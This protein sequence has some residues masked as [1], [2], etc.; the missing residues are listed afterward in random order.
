MVIKPPPRRCTTQP[1]NTNHMTRV[2]DLSA[3][4]APPAPTD[5]KKRHEPAEVKRWEDMLK[6]LYNEL[7]EG[8]V[9]EM[10]SKPN[11]PDV[12]RR[13]PHAVKEHY[14]QRWREQARTLNSSGF[15]H[16]VDEEL[17]RKEIESLIAQQENLRR[18]ALPLYKVDPAD[19]DLLPVGRIPRGV[20]YINSACAVSVH[21]G[22][23]THVW[24]RHADET[25]E[26]WASDWLPEPVRPALLEANEFTAQ[27]LF[28]LVGATGVVRVV[29]L[30]EDLMN[31]ARKPI[32][33]N[34]WQ[35]P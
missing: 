33:R 24:L 29:P 18:L 9:G 1:I 17:V 26:R 13:D 20:L 3:K 28:N 27:Q 7:M 21:E 2:L 15:P 5:V 4:P 19:Y 10:N 12:V 16:A 35:K 32:R 11:E 34:W 14:A 8:F 22:G 25:L 31:A 30:S 23:L 6:R